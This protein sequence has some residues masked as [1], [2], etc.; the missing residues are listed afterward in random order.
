MAER[1]QV[2]E[3]P[4]MPQEARKWTKVSA[5]TVKV[6]TGTDMFPQPASSPRR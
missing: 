2:E 3:L 6:E 5:Q 1:Y 4:E